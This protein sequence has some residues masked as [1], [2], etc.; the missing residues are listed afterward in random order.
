MTK[1]FPIT[2][3]QIRME[4]AERIVFA[5]VI[6]TWSFI[7]HWPLVIGHLLNVRCP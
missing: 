7:G 1:E 5:L 6:G 3:P 4:Q 2:N